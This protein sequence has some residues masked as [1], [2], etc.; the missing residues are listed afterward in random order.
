[1]NIDELIR[2]LHDDTR[3]RIDDRLTAIEL[4][5]MRRRLLSAEK[6][7]ILFEQLREL[8]EEILRLQPE[9]E[10]TADPHASR[11]GLLERER[12]ALERDMLDEVRERWRDMQEL[13]REHRNL[14]AERGA[15]NDRYRRLEY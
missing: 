11:R 10:H 13:R 15:T 9:G 5:L 7:T 3:L 14:L 2:D 12:R 8:S 4:E 6:T 1:M